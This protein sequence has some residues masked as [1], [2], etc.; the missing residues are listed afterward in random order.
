VVTDTRVG[1]GNDGD[2][3]S[4]IG[5]LGAARSRLEFM[6]HEFQ[7]DVNMIVDKMASP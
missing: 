4:L 3:T 6:A 5:D 1:A 2:A 7:Q